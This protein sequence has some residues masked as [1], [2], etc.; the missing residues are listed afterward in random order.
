MISQIH[1]CFCREFI[2]VNRRPNNS[3][4][5]SKLLDA[6]SLVFLRM[7]TRYKEGDIRTKREIISLIFPEKICFD[8]NECRTFRVNEAARFMFMIT[9][10]LHNKKTGK[11]MIYHSF[12]V[13]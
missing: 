11:E 1:R 6:V 10:A 3:R 2:E 13:L 8:G 12:P 7:Y 4:I 9:S 5:I